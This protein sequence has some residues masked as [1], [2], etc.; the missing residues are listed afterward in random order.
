[1]TRPVQSIA[2]A[3]AD[4]PEAPVCVAFS[5]GLDS[6]VLL[7]ALAQQPSLRARGL[8]A[9]HVDHGLH[10]QSR[11]WADRCMQ[12]CAALA[13]PVSVRRVRV[14]AGSGS[15]LEAAA[16]DARYAAFEADLRPGEWLALA[17]HRD[18]QVET[19]LLRLLRGSGSAALGGMARL[20]P[21]GPGRLWR[22]LLEL[23]RSALEAYA[24]EHRLEWVDDPANVDPRHDRTVLRRE[25]L[26]MLRA[27]WPGADAA[28]ARSARLLREDA[29]R[30]DQLDRQQL[31]ILQGLDPATLSLP[32]LAALAPPG[33][34]AVLRLWLGEL[35]LPTPPAA[36]IDRVDAELLAARGDATPCL[37]WPGAELRRYRDCLFAMAPQGELETGWNRRWDGHA[38]LQLPRG[39]GTLHLLGAPLRFDPPLTVAPRRG[40][41]RLVLPGRRHHT[42]LKDALQQLGIPP[43]QRARLPLVHASD[44]S[45]L[46]VGDLLHA[47][48]W[49]AQAQGRVL[50]W[51]PA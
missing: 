5:G 6:S 17:H 21:L 7:H 23:P 27:R 46:A 38:P 18:D 10:P 2:A 25:L 28:L 32:G 15:G 30:L 48:A 33:R 34:R 37:A 20:R 12:V 39:F 8:R 9:L 36:V 1:M 19:V 14:D 3:L 43:W 41:E 35:G 16:R 13:V 51:S 31:A 24:T 44:G 49:T 29:A 4:A 50:R 47:D 42:P 40:G 11:D 45:L 22:P 26:P